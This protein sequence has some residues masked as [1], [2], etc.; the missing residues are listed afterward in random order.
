MVDPGKHTTLQ[1]ALVVPLE[2]LNGV[3]GVLA[4]YQANRDAF[5]PDHLRILL[6]V[7]SKVALSVE[8]ALKYQ[9]AESSATTDYLTGLPNARS[10]F[11]H[12]AQE[13][14]RCRRMK[15]SLAVLVCDIDGFKQINDSFGHLEGDKLLREFTARLKDVCRGYDYVARMG[16]DEFV[17]TAPGLTP[18]AAAEKAERLN[19][20]AIEAG[21]HVCGRDVITLSVGIGFLSGR[22]VRCGTS[23]GRGGPQDVFDEADPSRG[24]GRRAIPRP[25]GRRRNRRLGPCW[26]ENARKIARHG[27]AIVA[28]VLLG[29]LL[30]ATLVRLA[31]GFDVDEAQ[32]DPHLNSE[33]VRALRQARL[34]QHNIFRFYFHSLQ[35]A[36]HGDLGTSLSLGQPVSVLLRERAPLTLRLVGIGLLLSWAV[37]MALALSAAWLRVSAYDALTTVISG[38]FLCI[39]AAVL[40]LLSVL[41]NVPGALAIGLI[42]FP[43]VYRYAR[44]LL[45]KAYS[46]PHIVTARAKGLSELRILFWHVVP[47]A[48]PQL[49][50]VAGVSV[51]IAVGAAI[52]V[53]ALCGL[54]GVGQ[55]AW[56][57]A[58]ARDLPLLTNLT[59]LVTLVTL[60]ANSGADVIGHMLRGQEA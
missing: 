32:L 39:P 27:L 17:I 33:S 23:A 29:G 46:L 2:G 31:P 30:S 4:M 7:A 43:R 11:M 42:V 8:N 37:A 26:G 22:W 51:S 3:V 55:L 24:S 36:A 44:N 41:W 12:L 45:A 47:V 54:A 50:A 40:A 16:G 59:I 35:R 25:P 21:R 15:T 18:E 9:Q 48:G 52:P 20:A 19:Q 56:Q 1:S 34:E 5:T 53:E 14:A 13:V 49:L 6:A 58:L 60:L 28:T 38:T 10:L 57:A